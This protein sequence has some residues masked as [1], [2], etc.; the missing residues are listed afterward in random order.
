M[1]SYAPVSLALLLVLLTA[2]Q[3]HAAVTPLLTVTCEAPPRRGHE[4]W[5]PCSRGCGPRR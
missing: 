3:A 2:C 4:L 5:G 1:R